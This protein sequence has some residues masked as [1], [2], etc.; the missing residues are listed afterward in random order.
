MKKIK[1]QLGVTLIELTVAMAISGII[2][3]PLVAIFSAQLRIPAT[4]T[5]QVVASRQVQSSSLVLI[6][7]A[8]AAQSFTPGD[9][10]QL[11]YGT[12]A[13]TEL[14]GEPIPVTAKYFF[15]PASSAINS[16]EAGQVLRT[17]SRGAQRGIPIIV[18]DDIFAYDRID[19]QVE[20]P[21]WDYDSG[22]NTWTYTEGKVI[23]T[24]IQ[25]HEAIGT[26]RRLETVAKTLV[27]AFRPQIERPVAKPI[28]GA[29]EGTDGF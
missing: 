20:D 28:F 16:N 24:I 12:F 19:F 21:L 13:W 9:P 22:N 17:L 5:V 7:D 15:R 10:L 14:A 2:A 8:Q 3:A 25:V 18:L 27:A 1:Q 4:I 29:A 11:E 23:V 6:K 26:S